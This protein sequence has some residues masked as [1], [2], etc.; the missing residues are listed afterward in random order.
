VLVTVALEAGRGDRGRADL[1][2]PRP[3]TSGA[4]R[5]DADVPAG[6]GQSLRSCHG[7]AAGAES[8]VLARPSTPWRTANARPDGRPALSIGAATHDPARLE[9]PAT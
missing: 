2:P 6:A 5:R 8:L 3:P 9:T 1:S 7:E 4:R